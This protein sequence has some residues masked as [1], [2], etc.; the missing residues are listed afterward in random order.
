MDRSCG[1]ALCETVWD[2]VG[3]SDKGQTG[4]RSHPS[5]EEF[6]AKNINEE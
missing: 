4:D 1:S 2:S 6:S 5:N 3:L